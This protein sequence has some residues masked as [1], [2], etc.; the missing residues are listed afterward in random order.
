MEFI[1]ISGMSG[2]GKSRAA[3]VLEDLGYYCVDNMPVAL[4]PKFAELCLATRGRYE[5]V[6]LVADVRE[7]ESFDELLQALDNL[8]EL[9]CTYRILYLETDVPTL[10]QR[11]KETRR[12]HPLAEKAGSIQQAVEA[13]RVLLSDIRERADFVI[14]TTGLTLGQLQQELYKIFV[15]PAAARPLQVN[16]MAFGFKY[17]I[18][19]E[20]DL[21][22]D[23]RF[24]PNPY[25]VAELREKTGMDREVRDFIFRHEDTQV[26]LSHL[27][28]LVGFLLPRYVDEGKHNLTIAVGCTG[29]KHRSVAIANA[30]AE[31][32]TEQGHA[33]RLLNRDVEKGV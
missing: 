23:V 16:V 4:L 12:K 18:P 31:F 19:I 27:T 32:I 14:N 3:D 10:V 8:W 13:E 24:L 28:G 30:L 26:F 22:F 33:A 5:R 15:G 9:D 29:G 7:K 25:Y 21:V 6:A 1:I 11:Y 17:G 20:S 2:A